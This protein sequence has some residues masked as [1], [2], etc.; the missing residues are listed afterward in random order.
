MTGSH[1]LFKRKKSAKKVRKNC[2][3]KYISAEN[4]LKY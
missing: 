4:S 2:T 3:L 1:P